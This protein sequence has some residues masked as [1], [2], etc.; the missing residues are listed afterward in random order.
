MTIR[1][2]RYPRASLGINTGGVGDDT[3]EATI[4]SQQDVDKVTGIGDGHRARCSFATSDNVCHDVIVEET[5]V[6]LFNADQYVCERR[7]APIPDTKV[8]VVH[9]L[10]QEAI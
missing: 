8:L 2:E 7:P 5:T 9:G 10:W 6:A 1:V 3:L 4:T